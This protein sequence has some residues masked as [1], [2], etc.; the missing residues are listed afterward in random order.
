MKIVGQVCWAAA[1]PFLCVL[2]VSCAKALIFLISTIQERVQLMPIHTATTIVQGLHGRFE[3][4]QENGCNGWR[5]VACTKT[6]L[7]KWNLLCFYRMNWRWAEMWFSML[8]N[9]KWIWLC[10]ETDMLSEVTVHACISKWSFCDFRAS[11][12]FILTV[13]SPAAQRT[14]THALT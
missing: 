9:A 13:R 8:V 3:G 2:P 4:Q 12:Q 11:C 10:K 7:F 6:R 5:I 1:H 14:L